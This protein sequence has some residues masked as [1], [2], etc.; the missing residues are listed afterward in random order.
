MNSFCPERRRFLGILV[1]MPVAF[2]LGCA[3][4]GGTPKAHPALTSPEES[5]NKLILAAGPWTS[6]EREKADN[7]VRRFLAAE[8]A[9]SPYL[10]S[11]GKVLQTL[12]GRFPA[13]TFALKEIDLKPLSPEERELLLK[14][15]EQLYNYVEV[16]FFV[17]HDPPW[18]ECQPDRMRYTRSPA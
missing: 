7:F 10:P 4:K 9:A 15:V 14:L 3:M 1:S 5:L 12:A 6:E 11:H 18:G 16:R 8:G 13:G 2:S 17:S